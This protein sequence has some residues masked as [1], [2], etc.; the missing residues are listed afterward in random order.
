MSDRDG[1][2]PVDHGNANAGISRRRFSATVAGGGVYT[3]V[4]QLFGAAVTSAQAP[5]QPGRPELCEMSAV[6]LA[7]RLARKQVSARE[8][9]T[10]HLAQIER[11]NP[12][13]NAIVT[14][15]AEQAMA[16]AAK[17][18]EAIMRRDPIGV[19]TAC[20]WRTKTSWTRRAF[21]PPADRRS[22]ATMCR[23]ATRSSCRG[24]ARPVR[25]P[26]A[27][28]TRRSLAPDRRPSIPYSVPRAIPMT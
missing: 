20:R 9:M 25:S 15:V 22:T 10:A 2:E 11:L 24:C 1:S 27:R 17:A 19:L 3:A 14:L 13:V 21:A 6:E 8:V 18:D 23:R 5:R 16:G 28:R 26:W 12:Q 4:H 7:A